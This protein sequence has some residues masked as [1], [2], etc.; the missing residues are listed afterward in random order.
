[1]LEALSKAIHN[2]QFFSNNRCRKF[3]D[4]ILVR[5]NCPTVKELVSRQYDISETAARDKCE[6][7]NGKRK[8]V[9]SRLQVATRDL[10]R[11]S[12]SS[13]LET[14]E[15]TR[16]GVMMGMTEPQEKDRKTIQSLTTSRN[17]IGKYLRS[18]L[19]WKQ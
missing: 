17:N 6:H 3:V 8:N 5:I 12:G 19:G 16:G 4:E 10:T 18:W 9:I 14:L 2:A 11:T 7:I 1:M 13:A 15:T